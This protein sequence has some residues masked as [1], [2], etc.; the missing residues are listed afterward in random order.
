MVAAPRRIRPWLDDMLRAK[1][2]ERLPTVLAE[3][4]IP[5]LP[6]RACFMASV[7]SLPSSECLKLR[8]W[9]LVLSPI[10]N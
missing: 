6:G 8:V 4:E 3:D 10:R 5:N 1:R 2:P 9:S 7:A